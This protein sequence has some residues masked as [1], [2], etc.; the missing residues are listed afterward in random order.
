[1]KQIVDRKSTPPSGSLVSGCVCALAA[2]AVLACWPARAGQLVQATDMAGI[3]EHIASSEYNI[4]WIED[5][6]VY[7]SANR[8]Q[9][10]RFTYYEDGFAAEPR[11]YGE[12]N[13][14]PWEIALRLQAFGKSADQAQSIAGARWTVNENAASADA[15]SIVVEYRNDRDGLR[16][17]FQVPAPPPGTDCLQLHFAAQA[18]G[19]DL[20]SNAGEN[21]VYFTDASGQEVVRYTDLHAWDAMGQELEAAMIRLDAT[22][23]DIA[24]NDEA[25]VYPIL[26]DPLTRQWYQSGTQTGEQYGYSV[27]DPGYV[28]GGNGNYAA[29]MVGA[30]QYDNGN[31]TYAGAVFV[32]YGVDVLTTGWSYLGNQAGERLGTSVATAGDLYANGYSG[33]VVGAPGYSSGGYTWNGIAYV[34]AGSANGPVGPVWSSAGMGNYT[35]YGQSV[36]G[37][38]NG[39]LGLPYGGFAIGAPYYLEEGYAGE[40]GIFM[41][42]LNGIVSV[43]S[44]SGSIYPADGLLGYSLA[45]EDVNRDGIADLIAGAPNM[46]NGSSAPGAAVVYYG[47]TLALMAARRPSG[48]RATEMASV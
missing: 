1:M 15:G 3:F 47:R 10:L 46:S 11:D 30:P 16:Q 13:P 5:T 24:V 31:A 41:G 25:A 18:T 42:S 14:K 43:G 20:Q 36:C 9:N 22:H 48:E 27:A 33:I 6:S 12:G 28:A 34:F 23:F 2:V 38:R 26:I 32:Y 40:I 17:N 44:I 4:R 45:L 19:L 29:V 39:M 21:F 7:R 8:A 35:R 37:V